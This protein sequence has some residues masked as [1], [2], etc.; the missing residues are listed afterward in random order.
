MFGTNAR[1]SDIMIQRFHS[2]LIKSPMEREKGGFLYYRH[3]KLKEFP[4]KHGHCFSGHGHP[5]T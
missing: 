2:S 1:L 4:P 5:L 3:S